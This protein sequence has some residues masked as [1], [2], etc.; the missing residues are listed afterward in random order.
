[1]TLFTKRG[2]DVFAG[3]NADGSSRK[4]INAEAARLLTEIERVIDAAVSGEGLK[5]YTTKSALDGDLAHAANTAAILIGESLTLDGLYVKAG[6]SGSGSWSRVGNVPGQGFVTATNA[7]AGT[8]NAIQATTPVAVNETQ[9]ILLPFAVDNTSGTVTVSFNGGTAL[10]VKTNAGEDPSVGGLKSGMTALGIVSGSTFRML[11][12]QVSSAI[13]AAAEAAADRA[14]AAA[15]ALPAIAAN[16]MLVD[17]AA[18]TARETKTF[19]EVRTLLGVVAAGAITANTMLVDNAAGNAR[20]TKTFT[21]VVSLLNVKALNADSG[22]SF[23]NTAATQ[24]IMPAGLFSGTWVAS[25]HFRLDDAQVDH[26]ENRSAGAFV[27]VANGP[28]GNN[29][30]GNNAL[31]LISTKDDIHG[32]A[33]GEIGAGRGLSFQNAWGDSSVWLMGGYKK[34]GDG[35]AAEGGMTTVEITGRRFTTDLSTLTHWMNCVLAFSPS[36][37]AT[38]A[39]DAAGARAMIGYY[40]EMHS[41]AGFANFLGITDGVEG[42]TGTMTYLLA[43]FRQRDLASR[44]FSVSA[45]TGDMESIANTAG[46][47]AGPVWTLNRA[48]TGAANDQLGRI[49]FN[50]RDASGN[51]DTFAR[52]T[53]N[54]NVATSGSETG[55]L[56]F[57]TVVSGAVT[58]QM[59]IRNGV[60]VGAPTGGFLGTGTLNAVGVYDDSVLLTCIPLQREFLDD[61]VVD[62]AKWHKISPTGHHATAKRFADL[63]AT[64]FDP[65]EAAQYFAKVRK[66]GALPGMPTFDEW[67]HNE[68]SIGELHNRLWLATEMLAVAV[69]DMNERI[70]A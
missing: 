32:A 48:K 16:R 61:G 45:N 11:S 1:M 10:A 56:A 28:L 18:G 60:R 50:S 64:G 47:G 20:E 35:S 62:L 22:F 23:A 49:L 44:Y 41:G 43:G 57:D 19:A 27:S 12:D 46:A 6:A 37:V 14:E 36:P 51:A 53:A 30:N 21:E 24:N 17:N 29:P 13:V 63:I 40:S 58:L 3:Y 67:R 59:D 25:H 52:I 69:M 65:R 68:L 38:W 33:T 34:V 42:G 55:G 2:V 5:V 26:T 7:G 31:F 66:D 70:A 15:A 39:S 9:L 54:I 4:V 8:A